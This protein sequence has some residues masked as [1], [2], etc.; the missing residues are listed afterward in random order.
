MTFCTFADVDTW[1]GNKPITF[2]AVRVVLRSPYAWHA[3][4]CFSMA[5]GNTGI[6]TYVTVG[7]A[8]NKTEP[9]LMLLLKLVFTYCF[10]SKWLLLY[11]TVSAVSSSSTG[12]LCPACQ[13]PGTAAC[14]CCLW[15]VPQDRGF[16]SCCCCSSPLP[17][18]F[19]K[20]TKGS[21]GAPSDGLGPKLTSE[22]MEMK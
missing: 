4:R 6:T 1:Q 3:N 15:A 18:S 19:W 21:Y 12:L 9:L 20:P 17:S 8:L 10:M 2:S 7:S 13:P 16:C 14:P 5:V 11:V 22:W